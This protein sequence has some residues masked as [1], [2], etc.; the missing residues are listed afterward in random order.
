MAIPSVDESALINAMRQFDDDLR[1]SPEFEGWEDNLAQLYA[2]NW[3]GRRYPPKKI[4]S[5]ATGVPVSTFSGGPESNAYLEQ[6]GLQIVA[7]RTDFLRI[8]LNTI[9][10]GYVASRT[11]EVM[12]SNAEMW[13]VF[14]R[15]ENF[16]QKHELLEKFPH[17]SVKA[18]VGQGVW[19]KVPWVVFLDNRETTSTQRGVYC[20]I[21]FRQNMSGLYFT[22]N[23]GVTDPLRQFG[24]V[25]GKQNI[26]DIANTL[27][28][29]CGLL[30][31]AGFSLAG[32]IDLQADKGLGTNYEVSTIAHKFYETSNLPEE[33]QLL[34]DLDA[35]LRTY[36][37]FV[38]NKLTVAPMNTPNALHLLFKWSSAREPRTIDLHK[39]VAE[40]EGSVWWGRFTTNS[41]RALARE[42]L[43]S[44]QQQIA[45]DSPT[46]AILYLNGGGKVWKARILELTDQADVIDTRRLPSYYTT[47]GCN[48]FSRLSDFQ[49]MSGEWLTQNVVL[50]R[51]PDPAA[52][53][54]ALRN[55]RTPLLIRIN[56]EVQSREDAQL[57]MLGTWRAGKREVSKIEA[58]LREHGGWAC[59]WSFP[60]KAAS[61]AILKKPFRIYINVGGA[62]FPLYMVVD[63]F[64]TSEGNEG[65]ESPW[66]EITE[67]ALVGVRRAGDSSSEVC[68]TWL[69]ISKIERISPSLDL[70]DF[71]PYDGLS[72]DGSLLSAVTFGYARRRTSQSVSMEWL[73]AQTL[74]DRE[75]L[76]EIVDAIRSTSP[77]V[78]FAG[79]PGTGKT[80]VAQCIAQYLVGGR[81]DRVRLV[82][83]H[84]SYSYEA[85]IEGL[86]PV[87]KNGGISFERE[88]GVVVEMVNQMITGGHAAADS[89]FYVLLI[90]EMNR[91]NLPRVFGELMYLFE[92][93]NKKVQLQYSRNFSLPPMF[94]VIGTMNTADRS[95]RSIDIALRRRFDVFEFPFSITVLERFFENR[96]NNVPGL[97][98]GLARLNQDLA[99]A[100]DRHH[101]IGHAFFMKDGI[102]RGMLRAIWDR[103]IFPLIEEYFF[104]EPDI[105]KEYAFEKYWPVETV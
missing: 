5:L 50:A 73:A 48:L 87:V 84:P 61:R 33:K 7:L 86:R 88:D 51:N 34:A 79:P 74:L 75:A 93:R 94:R 92:Y 44:L 19:A 24:A 40:R 12:S 76:Q 46:F 21:L 97:M 71:E 8:S 49:E 77:Q 95:I 98:D 57:S 102:D 81:E 53:G 22:F 37:A 89:P 32:D 35:L 28:P 25:K 43:S 68:K 6:R 2:I 55:Q 64:V 10:Q 36:D 9:L 38:V 60:V 29:T 67:E 20:V 101:T 3:E 52:L 23:Q 59:W 1:S 85:F 63:D 96:V 72:K 56:D 18:S 103:K 13:K 54:P 41:D 14:E 70:G 39:E 100:L 26:R 99:G 65:I 82:Q 11:S 62:T 80:W 91:A 69:K 31:V 4:I 47:D 27:R 104:D 105:V 30:R 45:S 83:F 15:C 42:T 66:P 58:F 90:D 78:V 17:I 16:L